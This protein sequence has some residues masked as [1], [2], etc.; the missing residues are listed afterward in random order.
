LINSTTLAADKVESTDFQ[1]PVNYTYTPVQ[2]DILQHLQTSLIVS[3]YQAGKVLVPMRFRLRSRSLT[4]KM[5]SMA[6]AFRIFSKH[7]IFNK[8]EHARFLAL[9]HR[10]RF[11]VQQVAIHAIQKVF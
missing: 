1:I 2:V 4:D 3:T 9:H 5:G 10:A 7:S 6:V 11:Q 8:P